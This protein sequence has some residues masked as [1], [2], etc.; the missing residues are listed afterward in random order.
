[1][2]HAFLTLAWALAHHW[3]E[4]TLL[5]EWKAGLIIQKLYHNDKEKKEFPVF[6]RIQRESENSVLSNV[7]S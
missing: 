7:D 4:Q 3:P 6:Y 1:M 5:Q 2:P